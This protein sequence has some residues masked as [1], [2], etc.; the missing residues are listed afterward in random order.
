MTR[1]SRAA[2]VRASRG[3]AADATIRLPLALRHATLPAGESDEG[4]QALDALK[5]VAREALSAF[6]A[7]YM[8]PK[9]RL[10]PLG[11]GD[12]AGIDLPSGTRSFVIREKMTFKPV[13]DGA[14]WDAHPAIHFRED[15]PPITVKSLRDLLRGAG[16]PEAEID[17][18]ARWYEDDDA[19]DGNVS[20]GLARQT[21]TAMQLRVAPILDR[22]Q[23]KI[24]RLPLDRRIAVLGPPGTGKTTTMVRRL[25]QKLDFAYLDD[26]ERGMAGGQDA[27]GLTHA[28]SWVLFTPTE[29]LRLYVKEALG[30]EGVPVHDDRLRTWDDFRW[31]VA[32]NELGILRRGN[33][34]GLV[35]P[36]SADDS[37]LSPQALGD[38]IGW[39][40][41]FDRWQST[42]FIEQMSVEGAR[43]RD[44]ADPRAAALGRRVVASIER[45]GG[46]V[47]RLLAE[48][49][50]LRAELVA[51]ARGFG[52]A[53]GDALAAPLG[54]FA[55]ADP[56]FLDAL[57]TTV[58]AL[59]RDTSDD[60]DDDDEDDVDVDED[61]GQ[62]PTSPRPSPQG[63]RLH[64]D[65]FR[66]AMRALAIAQASGRSLRPGGRAGRVIEWLRGR[67]LAVPDLKQTG[68]LLL[69][70]RAA[71]R[72]D[73]AP[74]TYLRR[75]PQR[76]RRFRR[77]MRAQGDWY[78][79]R[80]APAS[81]VHPAEVDLI[82]LA[83]LR[84]AAAIEGD[85]LLAGRLADRRPPLLDGIASLRRNQVLI[86]EMADFTPVQLA[87]MAAL[88]SA[89]TRSLFL[90]GDFNQRL[91]RWGCRSEQELVWAAPALAFERIATGYRQSR[92]LGDFARRLAGRQ[93]AVADDA[94]PFSDNIG[95]D[96]V[97]ATR[98]ASDEVR[99]RWLC[100]RIREIERTT[101][102]HIPTIAV[103]VPD[104]G[105]LTS[106]TAAL[107]TELAD[108]TL[109]ARAYA[110]GDAIG[111]TNDIR[112]FPIEHIKGLE[113]EA[114][115]FID[116]DRLAQE[117]PDL[118][119][120]YIYV[121]A[122]RAATFLGLTCRGE[123]LPAALT[124][125]GTPFGATW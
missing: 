56:G 72:L 3:I 55:R 53:I 124:D 81:S 20:E 92:K 26:D 71:G 13:E 78:P 82:M 79:D 86:D 119:D 90:C 68:D 99:A 46:D 100:D 2:R 96:P 60:P 85:R 101:D 125:P 122:T 123:T 118:F 39:F 65:I 114:V 49:A 16:V 51:L 8:S 110:Q 1:R 106:F 108:L 44:A 41:A 29:L 109:H 120:R 24:F 75:L 31:A 48:L 23:D 28:D 21:L 10:A 112:V 74:A 77:A 87:S 6:A 32:R 103:L 111:K 89:T 18:V 67:G 91:T 66:R 19:G 9:G 22:F 37:W 88:A 94:P 54:V 42:A 7:I 70:G 64:A 93:G 83:M 104:T 11:V 97:V 50:G 102:G 58:T 45:A 14:D 47:V 40:D 17:A 63:R 105:M 80:G 115:F 12:A 36:R 62:P 57:S 43:L 121:G 52:D 73:G 69:L 27:A 98:L 4:M 33:G 113:F 116:V 76:Y 15:A 35:M 5:P 38:G 34:G 25:R 84:G 59:L 95:F 107:N 61:V 117:K 30:K